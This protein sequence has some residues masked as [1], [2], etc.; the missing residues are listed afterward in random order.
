MLSG[1]VFYFFVYCVVPFSL[2]GSYQ[3]YK[4]FFKVENAKIEG[5][6]RKQAKRMPAAVI[7][8]SL[9]LSF[10]FLHT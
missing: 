2:I 3:F 1:H 7:I 9:Y 5:R 6:T 10:P 4:S 8:V